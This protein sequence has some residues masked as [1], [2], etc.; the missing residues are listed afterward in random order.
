MNM[1]PYQNSYVQPGRSRR[2]LAAWCEARLKEGH[3]KDALIGEMIREC[4]IE[5]AHQIYNEAKRVLTSRAQKLLIAGIILFLLGIG[6][7]YSTYNSA[8]SAGGGQYLV[9]FGA[10]I[11]GPICLVYALWSFSRLK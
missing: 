11:C 10:I 4:S 3:P 9:C 1:E 5:E 8:V 7:T 2:Q 6:I